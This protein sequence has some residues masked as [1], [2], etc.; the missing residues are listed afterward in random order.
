MQYRS[1]LLV[2]G[3]SERKLGKAMAT[4]ADI[5]VVDLADSVSVAA[6][7]DAR[8]MAVDWLEAHRRQ[9]LESR[10]LGRWVRIN[11]FESRQW[12]DD[13]M[14]VVRA[15]PD[16]IVLPNATGTEAVRQL[17]AELY[18]LEQANQV[19]SGS[20]KIMPI[21]GTSAHAACSIPSF[22]DVSLPRLAAISWEA[23]KLALA[24]GA[25]RQREAQLGWT[26][27][28]GLVR[29]QVLLAAHANGVL[30]V[31]SSFAGA[32]D[33]TVLKAAVQDA[34]ADGFTG[35]FAT[36]PAQVAEVNAVFT[37]S[38]EEIEYA[39]R[40]VA[41]FEANGDLGEFQIDRRTIGQSQ[42]QQARRILNLDTAQEQAP[43]SRIPILRTA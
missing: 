19:A 18:E 24:I 3:D 14:A 6:K 8:R 4:G 28:L 11:P 27:A 29:A 37:P 16:G 34:R 35:M 15:A 2:P 42:L 43:A 20:I 1:W 39:R 10:R 41:V 25:T 17:A 13:L 12:R 26:A 32:A 30:A 23:D 9:I 40:V 22:A 36:H 38:P 7:N 5:V 21:L 31:E 33:A